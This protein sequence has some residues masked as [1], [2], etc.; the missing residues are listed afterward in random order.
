MGAQRMRLEGGAGIGPAI[1]QCA[2][3]CACQSTSRPWC[4]PIPRNRAAMKFLR[5]RGKETRW[6]GPFTPRAPEALPAQGHT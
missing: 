5:V 6:G 2:A 1:S 4:G 3:G